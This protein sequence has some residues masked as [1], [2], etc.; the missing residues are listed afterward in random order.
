MYTAKQNGISELYNLNGVRAMLISSGLSSKLWRETIKPSTMYKICH[1]DNDKVPFPLYRDK[2]PP[3]SYLKVLGC[4]VF[5]SI[6]KKVY[7]K[8][9]MRAK[10][11]TKT[12]L[13]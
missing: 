13:S 8:L 9:D 7:R 6:P 2:I 1:K 11:R 4:K 3:I 12:P 10:V 5:I